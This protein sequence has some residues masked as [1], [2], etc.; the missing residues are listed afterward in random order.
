MVFGTMNMVD[1]HGSFLDLVD[2]RRWGFMSTFEV[3]VASD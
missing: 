3:L 1:F 2:K